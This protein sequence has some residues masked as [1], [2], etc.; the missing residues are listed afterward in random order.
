MPNFAV[1]RIITEYWVVQEV[2]YRVNT[3]D[4]VTVMC[5]AY[6]NKVDAKENDHSKSTGQH[7]HTFNIQGDE[8]INEAQYIDDLLASMQGSTKVNL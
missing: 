2:G 4:T 1:E 7:E 5:I 3:N 6:A 8:K